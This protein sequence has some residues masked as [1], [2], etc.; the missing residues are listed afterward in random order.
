MKLSE[1]TEWQAIDFFKFISAL[2]V[3]AIHFVPLAE[4]DNVGFWIKNVLCRLAVPFFF[5]A[6]GFF[7]AKKIKNISMV[8]KYIKHLFLLYVIYTIIYLPQVKNEGRLECG[9]KRYIQEVLLV[10][11]YTHLWFFVALILAV[12]LLYLVLNILKLNDKAIFVLACFLYCVGVMGNVYLSLIPKNL[13]FTN[14]IGLYYKYF[15]TTRNGIFFG[16]PLLAVGYLIKENMNG[17]EKRNYFKYTI[18]FFVG[19]I[20]ETLVSVK[21]T[22]FINRDMIFMI[23]P[24]S[25]SLFLAVCFISGKKQM[26]RGGE[27]LR[28]ISTLMF[29]WHYII[30]IYLNK[31]L[32]S[33]GYNIKSLE[34]YIVIVMITFL[35]SEI[36]LKISQYK[37]FKWL[38][39]L[40]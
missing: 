24:T 32:I 30:G 19:M 2:F 15:E 5:L 38:K 9:W 10:G 20:I 22:G 8:L 6:A 11:S 31:I 16:F 26:Q 25:I 29:A 34:K 23:L 33:L 7:I 28:K 39:Y 3:I 12:I 35:F 13:V 27:Q 4:V 37:Y 36:L 17:I 1:K 14:Y 40:Y 18:V 21:Y